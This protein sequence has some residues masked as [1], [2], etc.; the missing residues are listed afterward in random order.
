MKKSFLLSA[1]TAFMALVTF[2]SCEKEEEVSNTISGVWE[3]T[4][5]LFPRTFRG[6]ANNPVRTVL[7]FDQEK[8]KQTYGTGVAVEYFDNELLPVAYH[9]FDWD[10]WTRQKGDVGIEL[11]FSET[12]DKFSTMNY[13]LK[14]NEFYGKCYLNKQED[15]PFSF[16][17]TSAPDVNNVRVWG[18]NELIP[19]WRPTTFEGQLDIRRQY[20]GQ[21]YRP[22]SVVI[23][24]DC[25]PYYNES[26]VGY[27]NAYVRENYAE[28]PWGTSYLADGIRHWSKDGNIMR[29]YFSHSEESFGDYDLFDIVVYPDSLVGEVYPETNVVS[30]FNLKRVANPD[31]S[32]IKEWGITNRFA[33]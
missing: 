29:I 10:T 32:T 33:E 4:D 22:T 28:T 27:D 15:V 23:T 3:T 14:D 26:I 18:Y 2:T 6:Q 21:T 8:D 1:V 7:R 11:K 16:K 5:V 20:K 17:R 12:G 19:T 31:W 25:D 13:T 30:H 9:H 24:F